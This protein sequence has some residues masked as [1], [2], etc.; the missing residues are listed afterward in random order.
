MLRSIG[1]GVTRV[2]GPTAALGALANDRR[3]NLVFSDIMM[4]GSM[5]GVESAREIRKRR[6]G[7]PVLLATGYQEA[8]APATRDGFG[9]P[10]K[11]YTIE[12]SGAI[13][14]RLAERTE[15]FCSLSGWTLAF[16]S[17]NLTK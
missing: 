8:A 4:P 17:L 11:P 10:P 5:S 16:G 15:A 9:V 3:I 7:L 14:A 2:A 13:G 12:E 6:P 1:F